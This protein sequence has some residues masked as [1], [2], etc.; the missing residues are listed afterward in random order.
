M[1][2]SAAPRTVGSRRARKTSHINRLERTLVGAQHQISML[3]EELRAR[4]SAH[5]KLEARVDILQSAFA[6]RAIA[7]DELVKA[8]NDHEDQPEEMQAGLAKLESM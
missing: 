4:K 8:F 1:A 6:S 2:N 7:L 3:E 5:E